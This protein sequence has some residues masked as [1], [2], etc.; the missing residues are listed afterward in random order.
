VI[1]KNIPTEEDD[2]FGDVSNQVAS[3]PAPAPVSIPSNPTRNAPV[4]E[5]IPSEK[6]DELINDPDDIGLD[7]PQPTNSNS[8][9]MEDDTES[10]LS[11]FNFTT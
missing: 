3:T 1:S 6:F 4:A 8:I 7:A 5:P 9:G 11:H 10:I 2:V